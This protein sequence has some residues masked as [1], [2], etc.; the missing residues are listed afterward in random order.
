MIE[1]EE[2]KTGIHIVIDYFT[3][4]FPFI[5]YEEDSEYSIVNDIILMIGEFFNIQKDDIEECNYAMHR[6]EY[7]YKLSEHITLRLC[8]PELKSGHKHLFQNIKTNY[9]YYEENNRL[10]RMVKKKYEP[11]VFFVAGIINLSYKDI[12]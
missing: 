11:G 10:N 6:F 7:Q 5:C 4:T 1:L 3:A 2:K 9:H 12:P 8:G